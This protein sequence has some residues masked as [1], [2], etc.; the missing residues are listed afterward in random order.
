[1]CN[2]SE[3]RLCESIMSKIV[4]IFIKP[5]SFLM[6]LYNFSAMSLFTSFPLSQNTTDLFVTKNYFVFSKILY[7]WN[8]REIRKIYKNINISLDHLLP[9]Y[10]WK[11]FHVWICHNLFISLLTNIGYFKFLAMLQIKLMWT[12][13]CKSFRQHT[14]F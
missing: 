3:I 6:L 1:M 2:I 7:K 9:F 5:K 13:L 14:F 8:C 12:F 4:N 11:G 10:F